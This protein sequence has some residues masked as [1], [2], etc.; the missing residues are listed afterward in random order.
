M[1]IKKSAKTARTVKTT[2]KASTTTSKISSGKKISYQ[3]LWGMV[4]KEAYLLFADRGYTHGDD[5]YD[6][7]RAEKNVL[8]NLKKNKISIG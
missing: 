2:K 6:W 7:Y 3:E 4:E 1:V 8:S 5:Q